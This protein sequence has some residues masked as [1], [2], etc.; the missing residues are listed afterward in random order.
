[1]SNIITG[2]K[3]LLNKTNR[4]DRCFICGSV[5][6][7]AKFCPN[8]ITTIPKCDKCNNIGHSNKDCL[9]KPREITEALLNEKKMCC[10]VCKST[11][12]LICNKDNDY[13]IEG[14]NS[15]EIE[16]S[17]DEEDNKKEKIEKPKQSFKKKL[18]VF[19][20][21]PNESIY[22][23]KFCYKCGGIH[24]SEKCILGKLNKKN[25]TETERK[26]FP[27]I[28]EITNYTPISIKRLQSSDKILNKIKLSKENIF[29][30]II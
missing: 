29:N 7:Y 15:D 26:R 3:L 28:S 25:Y 14:Y 22:K 2:T 16:L 24:P 5:N 4:N 13:M 1:M 18:R 27:K 11:K 19:L 17:S 23:T 21:I 8:K 30:R 12:H 9:L 10:F 6:H 20:T